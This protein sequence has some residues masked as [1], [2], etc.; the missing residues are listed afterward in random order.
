MDHI[1][2]DYQEVRFAEIRVQW[3]NL[4]SYAMNLPVRLSDI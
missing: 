1:A 2:I 3:R 4:V